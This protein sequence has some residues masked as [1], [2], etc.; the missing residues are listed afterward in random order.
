MVQLYDG[1][2]PLPAPAQTANYFAPAVEWI[3]ARGGE[4]PC[5]R[6]V[7]KM[8]A[9]D[10]T[11]AV[12]KAA[13][14]KAGADVWVYSFLCPQILQMTKTMKLGRAVDEGPEHWSQK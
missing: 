7:L 14:A 9:G 12:V 6:D 4:V 3:A 5:A 11:P 2:E 10:G 13:L 1:D 8:T